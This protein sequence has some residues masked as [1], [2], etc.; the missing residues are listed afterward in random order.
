MGA[1]KSKQAV[2]NINSSLPPEVLG[3]IFQLLP[4]RALKMA[5][6]VCRLW[7]E[8]VEEQRLW[9]C[10]TL[11]VTKRNLTR[12]VKVL[13]SRRIPAVRRHYGQNRIQPL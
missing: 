13:G 7:R 10:H 2:T 8:V 3:R 5:V 12:V 4:R 6:L 9:A 1:K 11:R